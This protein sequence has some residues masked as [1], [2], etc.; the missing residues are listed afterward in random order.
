MGQARGPRGPVWPGPGS[1]GR[2]KIWRRTVCW[3]CI[4]LTLAVVPGLPAV[5]PSSPLSKHGLSDRPQPT[6]I[7]LISLFSSLG[8]R[9]LWSGQV[10]SLVSREGWARLGY[11]FV[12]C[13][14][15]TT[16]R[17]RSW[18]HTRLAT[19][20]KCSR[21]IFTNDPTTA[22]R[23]NLEAALLYITSIFLDVHI[24]SEITWRSEISPDSC[25]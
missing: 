21:L 6:G 22:K 16:Y 19:Q 14:D 1:V 23:E 8:P 25:L 13:S 15:H 17:A 3:C 11:N 9:L 7:A 18:S 10:W 2:G 24:N 5:R 20:T 4:T 12:K